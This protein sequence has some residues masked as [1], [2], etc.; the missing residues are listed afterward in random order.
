MEELDSSLVLNAKNLVIYPNE[1]A[2]PALSGGDLEFGFNG[3][4]GLKT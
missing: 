2:H 1:I 3:L 4:S